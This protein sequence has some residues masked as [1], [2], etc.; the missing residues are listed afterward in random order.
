MPTN[1]QSPI[2]RSTLIVFE[3]GGQNFDCYDNYSD[4]GENVCAVDGTH[5]TGKAHDNCFK[6]YVGGPFNAN[7][8]T[9]TF[10]NNTP[11]TIL[12][13]DVTRPRP[14]RFS[15]YGTIP[16]PVPV[17]PPTGPTQAQYDALK[18]Q[19]DA[20]KTQSDAL[21]AQ[22][23]T[24]QAQYN[25]LKTQDDS[26]NAQYAAINIQYTTLKS[27]YDAVNAKLAAIRI[28]GGW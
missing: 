19:Y 7:A 25:S 3:L 24:L 20:L 4:G 11:T 9:A 8:A 27:Q 6:N 28:A 14:S 5:A 21:T 2:G 17:P 23:N 15:R 16:V 26:L 18:A 1:A 10:N 12:T 22:L 13:W